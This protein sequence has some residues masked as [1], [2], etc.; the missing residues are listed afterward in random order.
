MKPEDFFGPEKKQFFFEDPFA[1]AEYVQKNS[2]Q[3]AQTVIEV[4]SNIAAKHFTFTRNLS[5]VGVMPPVVFPDA[6]HWLHQPGD[7]PEW[8]YTFNRMVFWVYLG[9]A[10][11]LTKNDAYAEAFVEQLTHWVKNVPNTPE[12]G[13]AWRS[14]EVGLRLTNWFKA[15]YCFQDSPAITEAFINLFCASVTEQCEFLMSVWDPFNL[16]SNWGVLAFQGL[17]IAGIMLPQTQRTSQFVTEATSR[18]TREAAIQIYRDGTHWEQ[19]ARYQTEV[20]HCFLEP[21][22]IAQRNNIELPASLL[23]NVRRMATVSLYMA[24]PDHIQLLLGDSDE[25]DLRL[26]LT[27]CAV[28][29][30]DAVLKTGGYGETLSAS[31]IWSIGEMGLEVYA[32]LRAQPP[33]PYLFCP[34][35]GN[36]YMRTNWEET[37]TWAHMH[38]GTLG[39]GHGHADKLHLDIYSRGEDVLMDAGRYTYAFGNE[40]I[41]FK[42]MTAHNTIMVDDVALYEPL[43]SWDTKKHA[44]AINQKYYADER[45][46]YTEGGHTGYMDQL[47][48]G[49][50]LNRKIIYLNPDIF[51]IAD[52][53]FT[54]GTHQYSQFFN[55]N[56]IGHL[57][58]KDETNWTY[59]SEN[60][61]ADVH[62]I[63]NGLT[64]QL[65]DTKIARH[66]GHYEMSHGI[67]TTWTARGSGCTYTFVTLKDS[68]SQNRLKVQK[69]DVTQGQLRFEDDA[70]EAFD[71]RFGN[72]RY[73]VVIAHKEY[74]ALTEAFTTGDCVGF[75]HV[76]VFNRS[77]GETETGTVLAW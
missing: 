33:A 2:P 63:A 23:K 6:I 69:L 5:E 60:L 74:A 48:N 55:F 67:K 28:L 47:D 8:V 72:D 58:K 44:R 20:L 56:N 36:A 13:K 39:S 38:C 34:D 73:I 61:V 37:A 4:A 68:G 16:I 22:L 64:S 32:A 35:S 27:E 21:M 51:I 29:Y 10:Y 43:G 18:L 65:T 30:R 12:N 25:M 17:F 1:I 15:I 53:Y 9:Q 31:A 19:S 46:W 59:E 3:F 54:A 45:Y 14:I 75:G 50:Y 70:I 7:D 24:K 62:F 66:Y 49:V 26:E 77:Q 40:R 57:V 11:A 76:V 52:E 42:G 41:Y 71:L